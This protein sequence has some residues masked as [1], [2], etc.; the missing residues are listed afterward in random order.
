MF[1]K[2]EEVRKL[3]GDSLTSS[4]HGQ[5]GTHGRAVFVRIGT[6]ACRRLEAW[7]AGLNTCIEPRVF[8]RDLGP[9]RQRESRCRLRKT[10]R[11][12]EGRLLGNRS[13]PSRAE[14]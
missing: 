2:L 9:A 12:R 1:D 13:S 7:P 3:V 14:N 11:L 10:F 4:D 5:M 8:A 6:A